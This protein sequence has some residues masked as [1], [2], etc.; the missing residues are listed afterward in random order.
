ME[1]TK[2]KPIE[3]NLKH[4]FYAIFSPF[5]RIK[6]R[7]PRTPG[8]SWRD[9]NNTSLDALGSNVRIRAQQFKVSPARIAS[10]DKGNKK[11]LRF[12][13]AGFIIS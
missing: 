3:K 5:Y 10:P 9:S 1:Y 2:E 12:T 4:R 13:R 6:Q 7:F 11:H 8:N